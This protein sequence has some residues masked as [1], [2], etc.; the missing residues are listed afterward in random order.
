MFKAGASA[1]LTKGGPI[2]RLIGVI[3]SC[4]SGKRRFQAASSSH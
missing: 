2:D 4:R 3:R 1:Y